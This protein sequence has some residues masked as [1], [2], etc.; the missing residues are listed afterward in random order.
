MKKRVLKPVD[1]STAVSEGSRADR[2]HK[3]RGIVDLLEIIRP[4]LKF[5]DR[6]YDN[7][8][9]VMKTFKIDGIGFG[10][11][12]TIEDRINY[13]NAIFIG[14]YD[15]NKILKFGGN[16]GFNVLKISIGARGKGKALAHYEPL[17]KHINITRYKRCLEKDKYLYFITSGGIH[18]FAHEYG[19]FLDYY[20]SLDK[21]KSNIAL[22]GGR[23]DTRTKMGF[24]D[25]IGIRF[26][27]L[28]YAIQN[29]SKG[30]PSPYMKRLAK[31]TDDLE[32]KYWLYRNEIFARTFESFITYKLAKNGIENL[33]LSKPKYNENFYLTNSELKK[34]EPLFDDLIK[35]IRKVL[36]K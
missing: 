8:E 11:W 36:I 5:K 25:K 19:H 9:R 35:E 17:M 3:A 18:S 31:V 16:M 10:N 30:N 27:N 23:N 13:I 7:S 15:L 4:N 29:D 1:T 12:V 6:D 20:V 32:N 24:K 21:M 33:F 34:I 28:M 2:F 26:D 22:S 14:L